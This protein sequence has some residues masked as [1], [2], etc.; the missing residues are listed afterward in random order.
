MF[1]KEETKQITKNAEVVIKDV[2]LNS[3]KDESSNGK[4]QRDRNKVELI[5]SRERQRET[6]RERVK[7][8][9]K[10]TPRRLSKQEA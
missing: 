2:L 5:L 1:T 3:S 8:Q 6:E 10:T 7:P 4:V 9:A